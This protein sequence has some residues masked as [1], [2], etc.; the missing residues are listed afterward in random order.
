MSSPSTDSRKVLLY[1]MRDLLHDVSS[2]CCED[3][4]SPRSRMP[5]MGASQTYVGLPPTTVCS[6]AR[7]KGSADIY[8]VPEIGSTS[9]AMIFPLAVECMAQAFDSVL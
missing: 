1:G 2:L 3:L 5:Q 6:F 7:E 9:V 8:R 4:A